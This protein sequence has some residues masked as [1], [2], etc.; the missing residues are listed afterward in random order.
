VVAVF[1]DTAGNHFYRIF[2]DR[3]PGVKTNQAEQLKGLE[4]ATHKVALSL[5]ARAAQIAHTR[6]ARNTNW[7]NAQ[8]IEYFYG[9]ITL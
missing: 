5:E 4:N 9:G 1:A 2:Y 6:M 3:Y 7:R 8:I